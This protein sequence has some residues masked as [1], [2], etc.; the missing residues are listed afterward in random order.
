MMIR[1]KAISFSQ[2]EGFQQGGFAQPAG[3]QQGGFAQPGAL[4]LTGLGNKQQ[5][6]LSCTFA[7]CYPWFMQEVR[8]PEQELELVALDLEEYQHLV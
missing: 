5:F 2:P 7:S 6:S 1:T 3:F 4:G 8:E